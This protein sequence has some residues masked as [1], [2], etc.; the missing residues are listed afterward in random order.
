MQPSAQMTNTAANLLPGEQ[1]SI[2]VSRVHE[3]REHLADR[4]S[5]VEHSKY[6]FGTKSHAKLTGK[7]IILMDDIVTTGASLGAAAAILR[8]SGA[9]RIYGLIFCQS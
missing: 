6:M 3:H 4:A 1:H 2:A 7:I 9:K 8:A 5:R